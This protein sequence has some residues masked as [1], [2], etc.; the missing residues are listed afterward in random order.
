MRGWRLPAAGCRESYSVRFHWTRQS[1]AFRPSTLFRSL[2]IY[3]LSPRPYPVR[4]PRFL[5]RK[6]EELVNPTGLALVS[7]FSIRCQIM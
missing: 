7:P 6:R 4:E 1:R 3:S 2:P 5:F